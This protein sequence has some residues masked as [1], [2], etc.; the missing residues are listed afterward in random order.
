MTQSGK[1]LE[2]TALGIALV[3]LAMLT[4]LVLAD[5]VLRSLKIDFYWGSEGGAILMAWSIFFA[6]PWVG[7]ER[8][9][10][11]TDF[12]VCHLPRGVQR[13]LALAGQILM[14][15][16]IA[17]VLWL[18]LELTWRNFETDARSQGILRLPLYIMQAGV[19]LGILLT[20]LAQCA[21]LL[22]DLRASQPNLLEPTQ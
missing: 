1:W 18:C 6:L 7:R 9:H 20:W 21:S 14:L 22:D 12:L 10:I 4:L 19:C 2:R 3:F 11:S 5:V 13:G 16:Y 15:A 17:L 8:Q